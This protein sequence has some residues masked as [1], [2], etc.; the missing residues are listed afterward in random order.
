MT[1]VTAAAA[2][3]T[4]AFTLKA[5]FNGKLRLSPGHVVLSNQ[6]S[7]SPGSAYTSDLMF[8]NQTGRRIEF[9]LQNI[10]NVPKD[11]PKSLYTLGRLDVTI[12]IGDKVVFCGKYRDALG[13]SSD[14]LVVGAGEQ[15]PIRVTYIISPESGD[16]DQGLAY[17]VD[18][19]FAVRAVERESSDPAGKP[20]EKKDSPQTGRGAPVILYL[21]AAAVSI[22]LLATA[23]KRRSTARNEKE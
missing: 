13:L 11:H 20:Y 22:A 10:L 23:V 7:L 16:N 6:K 14:W 19:R 12:T 2:E 18:Y 15:M 1:A 17:T 5:T 21:G 8:K 3:S 4:D 9:S